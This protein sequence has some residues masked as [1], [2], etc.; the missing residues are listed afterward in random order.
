M[1]VANT[2]WY[3]Y[4]FRLSL[5]Q[6]LR[7]KG[8]QVVLV[9]PP[10][11]F[12]PAIQREG[13]C[14][15]QWGLDRRS[16]NPLKE[17]IALFQLW[18]VYRREKPDLVHHLTVKP[19][20]YGSL[21]AVFAGVP[22]I[23]NA[24]TGLG[25]LF[26][27]DDWL[28]RQV[29]RLVKGLYR[30]VLNRPNAVVIFENETNRRQFI[31]EGLVREDQAYLIEGVGV[32]V[33]RFSPQPEA[34]GVPVVLFP[35][36]LL[37]EKGIYTLIEAARL[38]KPRCEVRFWL[39][40]DVDEGNP[41]SVSPAEVSG[42][43]EEGL[44]EWLGWQVDMPAVYAQ[45]NLVVLPSWGEGIPTALLE[46]GAC[47]RAVVTTDAPGCRD[48]IE[49]GFNGRLV[50][51]EDAQ[52]LAEAINELIHNPAERQRMGE[53]ARRRVVERFSDDVVNRQTWQVYQ[54]VLDNLRRNR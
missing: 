35:A 13:F 23:V 27:N 42:W 4:N 16:M 29:R 1:L 38:L 46:A 50:T 18:L 39:A 17:L 14:W 49:D 12:V 48:V 5:A 43:A 26:L 41:G 44:V 52:G 8:W 15:V 28:T 24:I 11:R 31:E 25:Y 33:E 22:G 34:E 10:G 45:S 9:S 2:D 20:L 53:N 36:R 37:R 51:V 21:A 40:G 32:D 47:A 19:V 3:L 30:W 7:Q 6:F 54:Q